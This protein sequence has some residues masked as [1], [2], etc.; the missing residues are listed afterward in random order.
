L[1]KIYPVFANL[2]DQYII[3]RSC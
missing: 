2:T 3:E 1:V